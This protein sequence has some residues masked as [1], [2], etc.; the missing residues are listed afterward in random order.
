MKSA[1]EQNIR[2]KGSPSGGAVEQ[3][4]TEGAKRRAHR[5]RMTPSGPSGHLPQRGRLGEK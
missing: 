2:V 3:S 1:F 5:R 4:E